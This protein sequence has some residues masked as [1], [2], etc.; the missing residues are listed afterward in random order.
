M[1]ESKPPDRSVVLCIDDETIGL[2]LRSRMLEL[3]GYA[4]LQASSGAEGLE[5]FRK[6]NP[7]LVVMDQSMPGMSGEEV[8]EQIRRMNPTTPLI[9]HSACVDLSRESR[10]LFNAFVP[11]GENNGNLLRQMQHLLSIGKC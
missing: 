6:T 8:A 7:D 2:R 4:V 3:E 11:K 1:T 5:L 10:S 9:L